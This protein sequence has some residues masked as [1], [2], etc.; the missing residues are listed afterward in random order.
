MTAEYP[1]EQQNPPND[2]GMRTSDDQPQPRVRVPKEFEQEQAQGDP[3]G[4]DS[5]WE[6]GEHLGQFQEKHAEER[7]EGHRQA[8]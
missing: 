7:D 2:P 6:P 4:I 1:K 5:G 3:R 8:S